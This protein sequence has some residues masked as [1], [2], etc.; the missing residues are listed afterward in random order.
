MRDGE[1]IIKYSNGNEIIAKTT[2]ETEQCLIHNGGISCLF[3]SHQKLHPMPK[4]QIAIVADPVSGA[5]WEV[6]D[7]VG[8]IV[9]SSIAG[10]LS[11][12]LIKK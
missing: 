9:P 5:S 7:E 12:L 2:P 11:G 1:A 3:S 4:K 6:E 8:W 10:L